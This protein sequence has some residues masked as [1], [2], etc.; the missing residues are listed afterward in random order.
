[1]P[2]EVSVNAAAVSQST[3]PRHGEGGEQ[4]DGDQRRAVDGERPADAD[5]HRQGAHHQMAEGGGADGQGPCAHKTAITLLLARVP[6][7]P[8]ANRMAE[9]MS[10]ASSD[11]G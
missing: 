1:M 2:Y 4:A 8:M 7:N 9:T 11:M 10:K 5:G 6:Y 3:Q